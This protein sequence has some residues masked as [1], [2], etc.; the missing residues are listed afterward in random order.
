MNNQGNI[1]SNGT[2]TI[3][4]NIASEGGNSGGGSINIF[5]LIL[6]NQG[7]ISAIGGKTDS[8]S[9][10]KSGAGGDGSVTLTKINIYF[11]I[12][13]NNR[14]KTTDSINL[15]DIDDTNSVNLF[16]QYGFNI[17]DINETVINKIV[18]NKYNISMLK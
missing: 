6:L 7:D 8:T 4:S 5:Y 15:T 11:L 14:I 9:V 2:G 10:Y 12:K 3:S 17:Y 1:E 16:K 18:N 13:D